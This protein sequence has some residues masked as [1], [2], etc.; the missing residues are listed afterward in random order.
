MTVE[1]SVNG[2]SLHKKEL[3]GTAQ[4]LSSSLSDANGTWST[5]S[6]MKHLWRSLSHSEIILN[7]PEGLLYDVG[8]G[9]H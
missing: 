8:R 5:E 9:A 3:S 6:R 7:A 2:L 1:C 4:A